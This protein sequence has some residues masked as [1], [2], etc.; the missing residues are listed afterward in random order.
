MSKLTPYSRAC[1]RCRTCGEGLWNQQHEGWTR[2]LR[3][4]LWACAAAAPWVPA[5]LPVHR[6]GRGGTEGGVGR[7]RTR[8]LCNGG[9]QP[10]RD[11]TSARVAAEGCV[12]LGRPWCMGH[13]AT[14]LAS[15]GSPRQRDRETARPAPLMGWAM[16]R[17]S[18]TFCSTMR[19]VTPASWLIWTIFPNTSPTMLGARPMEGSSS[20]KGKV[21]AL[22]TRAWGP[23]SLARSV[24]SV[25]GAQSGLAIKG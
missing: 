8:G 5:C 7:A 14:R 12:A 16:R 15:R 24:R 1:L 10:A 2:G 13:A 21:Q 20:I 22:G 18:R 4:I 9:V 19:I 23:A 3:R 25:A 17:T 6:E 11:A